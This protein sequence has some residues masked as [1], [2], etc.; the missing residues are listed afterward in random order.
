[1]LKTSSDVD[2]FIED[3]LPQEI[4]ASACVLGLYQSENEAGA[5][6]SCISLR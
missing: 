2:E 3:C 5:M 6:A 1:L 4:S